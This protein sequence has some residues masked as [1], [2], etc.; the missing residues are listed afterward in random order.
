MIYN[1][2]SSGMSAMKCAMC[3]K[4]TEYSIC[5]ECLSKRI[6]VIQIP[7]VIELTECSVCGNFRLDRWKS[8]DFYDALSHQFFRNALFY[9][10][11]ELRNFEF[12]I[13][14]DRC[15]VKLWGDLRGHALKLEKEAKIRIKRVACEK[16][17]RQSGGYYESIIQIRANKRKIREEEIKFIIDMIKS[18]L[19]RESDN[20]RAF[21]TK[22]ETKREGV[23][24]YLGDK[25]IGEKI[26]RSVAKSFGAEIKESKKIAGKRD[27]KDL[28]RFTY[29]IK[30]PEY[31]KGDVVEDNG[32][33]A[34]VSNVEK[35]KA[36]SIKNG[37]SINLKSP[38]L[39]AR[40]EDIFES[41][42][43]NLDD[44]TLEVIDPE[45]YK[46]ITIEKPEMEFSVGDKVYLVRY[47][48]KVLAIH[49]SLIS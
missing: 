27:G 26:S 39:I 34:V 2:L 41:Y 32:V 38:K 31:L 6:E 15:L 20:P 5:G 10:E 48:D 45:S 14:E 12:E 36:L 19:E 40:R 1:P 8:V 21:V 30:F 11:F 47:E 13:N 33:I 44:K 24:I 42:V 46:V 9:E 7:N 4:E 28:Y 18:L 43:V 16:C 29:L 35:K 49:P 3:G 25:K 22:I 37:K 17:S 23:D